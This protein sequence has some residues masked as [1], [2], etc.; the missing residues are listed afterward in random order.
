MSFFAKSGKIP[1]LKRSLQRLTAAQNYCKF[2]N[3]E[4]KLKINEMEICSILSKKI[5]VSIYQKYALIWF[6]TR[7][8]PY[9]VII[10]HRS[11]YKMN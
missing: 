2:V 3:P 10:V 5:F 8:F 6:L 4:S 7:L 9:I 11:L 1:V